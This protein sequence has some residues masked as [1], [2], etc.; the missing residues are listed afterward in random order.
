[1]ACIWHN[2]RGAQCHDKLHGQIDKFVRT[3]VTFL[4]NEF[5]DYDQL[6]L[7]TVMLDAAEL[8]SAASDDDDDP[9]QSDDEDRYDVPVE[10][11]PETVVIPLPSNIGIE[12]C[13]E[14]GITDLVLQ[15]ISL[16]KGQA[17]DALHAIRVNLANKAVLFHT[18]VWSAKSQAQSTRAW[19]WV[20]SV[21]K[22]L[23]LNVHIYSKCCSQL[24]YP[25][26]DDLLVKFRPL[27]K[28]DLK[29]TMVVAD[30]N[31]HSQ[32][33]STLAWFWSIDV[34]GHSTSNDWVNELITKCLCLEIAKLMLTFTIINDHHLISIPSSFVVIHPSHIG[35]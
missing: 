22:I 11:I 21:D 32:R 33:N 4:G 16:R 7:M 26:T 18:M 17:N 27:E 29:A 28:A 35:P 3:A 13:A 5:D 8:D 9:D 15:E 24:V 19:A 30:P 14:W 10:F 34:Q 23:H 31:D 6:D 12:R 1:M 20:H 25:G 2:I